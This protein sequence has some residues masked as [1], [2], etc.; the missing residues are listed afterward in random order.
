MPGIVGIVSKGN[1]ADNENDLRDM[2]SSMYHESFYNIGRYV[3][4]SMGLYIGWSCHTN[5]FADCMPIH[6]ESGKIVLFLNGEVFS[7]HILLQGLKDKGHQFDDGDA[8]YLVHL[9]EEQGSKFFEN[10]NGQYSG[11]LLDDHIKKAFLFNDRYGM[12]RVFLHEGK[13]ALHFANNAKA[14]LRV[15]PATREFDPVGVAEYLTCGGTIGA[16]S[17]FNNIHVLPAASLWT[18]ATSGVEKKSYYFERKEWECQERLDEKCFNDKVIEIVPTVINK[19]GKAKIPSGISLTG[20]LDSRILVACLYMEPGEYPCYTFGSMHRDTYDV[21]IAREVAKACG[22]SYNVLIV[23]DDYLRDFPRYLEKAVTLSDGYLGL[24]GA[25]EL[26]VNSLARNIAPIRITGN[27][28][29]E[30]IRGVRAFKAVMPQANFLSAD[31]HPFVENAQKTFRQ[32]EKVDPVSFA[33]FNLAPYQG[34]G[35]LSIEQAMVIMRTPFLDNELV[36]LMYTQPLGYSNGTELSASIIKKFKP[37]LMEI[38]TDRGD[39]GPK[40]L[41][42][43]YLMRFNRLVTFKG[44]YW[45]SHG[46]P[47]WVATLTRIMPWL[48]LEGIMIG[49]HKFQ[50]YRSWLRSELADYV[51]DTLQSNRY[52][53]PFFDRRKVTEMINDHLKGQKNYV[54][55]IDKALTMVLS[56][57]LLFNQDNL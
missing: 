7:D 39:I 24:S 23:G 14:L 18:I 48:N 25:S 37:D 2:M 44:E 36:K 38:P 15:L 49:R 55:E 12:Q 17:L 54:D 8:S 43:K 47:Q 35:R 11:I 16:R 53:P 19:Y 21:R 6:N 4:H 56:V 28:G 33:M 10:L 46:M 9:Y 42:A 27:Y 31:F 26:Y 22:Q 41:L 52:L 57:K 20:G 34:Y 51:R 3:N 50:H 29:S 40:L 32:F 30:L 13:S 45:I 5:S 1:K